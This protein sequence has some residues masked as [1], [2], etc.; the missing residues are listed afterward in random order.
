[1][2]RRAA[3][4]LQRVERLMD[5]A[6]RALASTPGAATTGQRGAG[7]PHPDTLAETANRGSAVRGN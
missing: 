1:L 4:I 2:T 7:V 6:T 3:D 5:D